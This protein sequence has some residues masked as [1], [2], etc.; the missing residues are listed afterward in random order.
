LGCDTSDL[1]ARI[2]KLEDSNKR[3]RE[4][5]EALK[6]S[7]EE[8]RQKAAAQQQQRAREE[9]DPDAMFAVDVAE[10]VKG[11]QVEGPATA[12]VTIVEAWDF[13]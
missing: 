13:A 2:Q 1:E 6:Q 10:D 11:G 8:Q 12:G 4:S 3:Y 5:W 7:Y 9:P